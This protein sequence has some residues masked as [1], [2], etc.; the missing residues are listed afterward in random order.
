MRR[1]AL[2]CVVFAA[3]VLAGIAVL[4]PGHHVPTPEE[5]GA[6]A[7]VAAA[8]GGRVVQ[9]TCATDHCGVVVQQPG[10]A[11]CQGWV[12]PLRDGQL[13]APRRSALV[14]C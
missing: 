12:V 2:A 8:S 6:R 7:A 9:A 10:A 14:H 13:G 5:R 4:Q 3:G 11:V 1:A